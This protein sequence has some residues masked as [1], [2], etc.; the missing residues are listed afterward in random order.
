MPALAAVAVRDRGQGSAARSAPS[1]ASA[2]SS[3]S[4]ALSFATPGLYLRSPRLRSPRSR[5]ASLTKL[6]RPWLL[7][8]VHSIGLAL[9]SA[10]I[11]GQAHDHLAP[12]GAGV[13]RAADDVRRA[14]PARLPCSRSA[15]FERGDGAGAGAGVRRGSVQRCST[16]A[17][18]HAD[19]TVGVNHAFAG[20]DGWRRPAWRSSR[21]YPS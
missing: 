20:E 2:R 11:L 12:P 6:Y 13:G 19:V 8:A 17:S 1:S 9:G 3:C 5:T 4:S 15:T 10:H 7:L 21:R 18:A 14:R 16:A